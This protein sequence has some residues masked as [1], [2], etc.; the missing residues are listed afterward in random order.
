MP[1]NPI[2]HYM[3]EATQVANSSAEKDLRVLV[4][5]KWDLKQRCIPVARK[6]TCTLSYLRRNVTSR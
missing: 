6:V 1:L 4:D 2:H 3:L 5:I